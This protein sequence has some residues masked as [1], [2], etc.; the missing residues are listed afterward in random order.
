MAFQRSVDETAGRR[1]PGI[2]LDITDDF[3]PTM[4]LATQLRATITAIAASNRRIFALKLYVEDMA[5]SRWTV[6]FLRFTTQTNTC[7]T[8]GHADIGLLCRFVVNA[9]RR[10]KGHA[11]GST[12]ER[13]R[14]E[15]R[16]HAPYHSTS[17]PVRDQ[18]VCRSDLIQQK[19]TQRRMPADRGSLLPCGPAR[20]VAMTEKHKLKA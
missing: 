18:T 4:T 10:R 7:R 12:G 17:D 16:R 8:A 14:D 20:A 6:D 19:R 3:T 2:R 15:Q 13:D 5:E 9:M 1:A 11:P